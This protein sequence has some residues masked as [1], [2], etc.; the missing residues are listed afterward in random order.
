MHDETNTQARVA[1]V[2]GA[3]KRIGRAI[4]LGLAK[5]GWDVAVHYR[6]SE[7]E[8][9]ATARDVEALGRRAALLQCDL[10]DAA[11]VRALLGRAIAALGPVTCVVNNASQFDYDSAA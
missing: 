6:G 9:R 11:A 1:L 2:T 5:A 8:A 7:Q 3:G 10:S 4:A